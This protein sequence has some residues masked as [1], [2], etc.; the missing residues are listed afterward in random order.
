MRRPMIR[1]VCCR[2]R[3]RSQPR[4]HR[5]HPLS[6]RCPRPGPM[7]WE[8]SKAVSICSHRS[9]DQSCLLAVN[10]AAAPKV[11]NLMVQLL[12]VVRDRRRKGNAAASER[13]NGDASDNGAPTPTA[14]RAVLPRAGMRVDRFGNAGQIAS[15]A[16]LDR[17]HCGSNSFFRRAC[18]RASNDFTVPGRHERATAISAS[19]SIS[20]YR[21]TTAAR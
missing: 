17:R 13:E 10:D 6:A 21:S 9:C 19:D 2:N 8:Q 15:K 11:V 7:W 16:I 18:A 12:N 1:R 5:A 3:L 14:P 20:T 4:I